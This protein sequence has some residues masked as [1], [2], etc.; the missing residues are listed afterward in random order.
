MSDFP[1]QGL[2]APVRLAELLNRCLVILIQCLNPLP[3]VNTLPLL[4]PELLTAVV[5]YE[6]PANSYR[7]PKEITVEG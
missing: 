4:M 5:L 2:D 1:N 3:G 6:V 7:F